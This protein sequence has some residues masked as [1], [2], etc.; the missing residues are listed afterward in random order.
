M[1][2]KRADEERVGRRAGRVEELGQR[3]GAVAKG[4]CARSA[5][6]RE[7]SPAVRLPIGEC[8]S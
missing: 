4:N 2:E 8:R 6:E 5:R 1:V 7:R 3:R